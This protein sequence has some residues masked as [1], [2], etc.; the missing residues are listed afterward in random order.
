MPNSE[1]PNAENPI[2]SR[3]TSLRQRG[4]RGDIFRYRSTFYLKLFFLNIFFRILLLS[5][6]LKKK[7]LFVNI[8][9]LCFDA[10]LDLLTNVKYLIKLDQV[11]IDNNVFRLHY[12][13][14]SFLLAIC[15]II[16]TSKQ[17]IGD[18]ID[19]VLDSNL[20]QEAINTYCWIFSTFTISNG[21]GTTG[22]K[23]RA[24]PYPGVGN[25]YEG[26]EIV[27]QKYYQWVCFILAIQAAM[28]IFP[29]C[30]WRVWEGGRIKMLVADLE[31]YIR[32]K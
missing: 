17:Y 25:E 5:C 10:M 16:V 26:S 6:Q 9:M 29:H 20:D 28:F 11:C 3:E 32:G 1:F 15:S 12:K 30:L 13:A 18:P 27:H 4:Y 19:C 21:D 31:Y 23:H 2:F 24:E 14:T 8:Q 7:I 22:K